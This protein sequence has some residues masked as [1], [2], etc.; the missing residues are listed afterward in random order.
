MLVVHRDAAI[1][2]L[3]L[4]PQALI[5]ELA[6]LS[7]S[8]LR[9]MTNIDGA[10]LVSP[11]ARCH[12]VG[13]ILDGHATGTGDV[14]RGARFNS[15]VRYRKGAGDDCLVIIVSEDGMINLLPDLNRRVQRS[16]IERA[17]ADHEAASQGEVNF[18]E[19]F[20]HD[21]HIV[22]LAFS[23]N[24]GH[25]DQVNAARG[26]VEDYRWSISQMRVTQGELAADPAMNDS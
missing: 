12:A 22:A 5:I 21:E 9:A 7:G 18:E 10:V 17:L 14:S 23:L 4:V 6:V 20:R 3:R 15:A 24:A 13:V 2:A 1:E 26:R 11:D 8:A 16:E 19:F 25:C